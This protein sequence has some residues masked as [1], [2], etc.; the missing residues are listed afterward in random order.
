MGN[1]KGKE[2]KEEKEMIDWL[3]KEFEKEENILDKFYNNEIIRIEKTFEGKKH[4]FF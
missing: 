3:V 2:E 1:S 4:F